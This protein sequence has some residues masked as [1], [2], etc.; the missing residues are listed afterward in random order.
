MKNN[1]STEIYETNSIHALKDSKTNCSKSL[2]KIKI[3]LVIINKSCF[4]ILHK[5]LRA[6]ASMHL[7]KMPIGQKQVSLSR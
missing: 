6:D 4:Q 1:R 3:N 7:C 5:Y 2:T